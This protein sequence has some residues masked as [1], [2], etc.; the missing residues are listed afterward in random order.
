MFLYTDSL[1][2]SVLVSTA[3]RVE[4]PP[5]VSHIFCPVIE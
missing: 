1:P 4:V 2:S 5:L 3:T